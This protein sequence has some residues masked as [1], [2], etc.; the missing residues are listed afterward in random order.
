MLDDFPSPAPNDFAPRM[1][2][3]YGEILTDGTA[4]EL[5]RVGDQIMLCHWNGSEARALPFLD[6]DDVVY[7]PP[8]LDPSLSSAIR[9]PGLPVDFT[10]L[11]TLFQK[12]VRVFEECGFSSV[13]ARYCAL[14]ML[15][16]WFPEFFFSPLTLI[17]YCPDL[18]LA[19]ILF[20]LLSCVSSQ[21]LD[22]GTCAQSTL[23]V[24]TDVVG[25]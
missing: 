14:F 25:S 17:V 9:L 15:A 3:T 11:E 23:L 2:V 19:G 10:S 18:K 22:S 7:T 8:Q 4:I 13:V 24:D 16:S 20:N 12:A 6:S 1:R 5:V 21:L